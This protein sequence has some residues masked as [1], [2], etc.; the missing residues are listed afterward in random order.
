MGY[1]DRAMFEKSTKFYAESATEW[2]LKLIVWEFF[3]TLTWS[4]RA[5]NC[6]QKADPRDPL[7][8]LLGADGPA[9]GCGSA[10]TAGVRDSMGTGRN[11]RVATLPHFD[12]TISGAID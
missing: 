2:Q 5:R 11:R 12:F 9:R 6:A 7:A 3:C 1:D 8:P 10:G 4:G